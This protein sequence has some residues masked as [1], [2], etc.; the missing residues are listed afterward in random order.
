[1]ATDAGYS[2]SRAS[3]ITK[4]L[5]LSEGFSPLFYFL[6]KHQLANPKTGELSFRGLPASDRYLIGLLSYVTYCADGKILL[7]YLEPELVPD[8]HLK[9]SPPL[10]CA[11]SP[12][13]V[14]IFLLKKP[15]TTGTGAAFSDPMVTELMCLYKCVG[16]PA[17]FMF[18]DLLVN[19]VKR[20]ICMTKGLV[21]RETLI[22][23]KNETE[24]FHDLLSFLDWH[25]GGSYTPGLTSKMI[26]VYRGTALSKLH[27]DV[28]TRYTLF[29]FMG[30][31][32]AY[33]AG[34]SRVQVRES[35]IFDADGI[36]L[37]SMRKFAA[38]DSAP[39]FSAAQKSMEGAASLAFIVS[40]T[41][42]ARVD[43]PMDTS[44][45][46]LFQYDVDNFLGLTDMSLFESLPV[47]GYPF[48]DR[49]KQNYQVKTLDDY[50][51]YAI[52]TQ[53][54]CTTFNSVEDTFNF[55][56]IFPHLAALRGI[57]EEISQGT[58]MGTPLEMLRLKVDLL[59]KLLLE[60]S[61][62]IS[63]EPT[64]TFFQKMAMK[65]RH[66]ESF[67]G[68]FGLPIAPWGIVGVPDGD[69][70]LAARVFDTAIMSQMFR[71]TLGLTRCA[72]GAL[73][74]TYIFHNTAPRWCLRRCM[75][76]NY[77][78]HG[79]GKTYTNQGIQSLLGSVEGVF[80]ELSS[81]TDAALKYVDEINTT[82]I[83][84]MDDVGFSATQLK[85]LRMESSS[86]AAQFKGILDKG[87]LRNTMAE[88]SEGSKKHVT[89]VRTAVHN[90]GFI[91]NTNTVSTF[92]AAWKDRCLILG[93]EPPSAVK[94]AH[95]GEARMQ[96]KIAEAGLGSVTETLFLR[97]NLLQTVIYTLCSDGDIDGR[98][99]MFMSTILD[100]LQ[101]TY[102]SF[103]GGNGSSVSRGDFK[104]QDMAIGEALRLAITAVLDLWLPP[105]MIIPATR[106]GETSGS[107]AQRL[108][109]FRT[110][111]IEFM[112]LPEIT[113]E[114][115]AQ[116]QLF[117]PGCLVQ[118]T[119]MTF[120]QETDGV[121]QRVAQFIDRVLNNTRTVFSIKEGKDALVQLDNP[122]FYDP[123]FEEDVGIF[124]T[125]MGISVKRGTSGVSVVVSMEDGKDSRV[126]SVTMDQNL[127]LELHNNSYPESISGL[128]DT[129]VCGFLEEFSEFPAVRTFTLTDPLQTNVMTL[130]A[131]SG[132][133]KGI[134][135][136]APGVF[137]IH[138]DFLNIG[139]ECLRR[140]LAQSAPLDGW[141][142][143]ED[144]YAFIAP[145]FDN[146]LGSPP[147]VEG[148]LVGE[149]FTDLVYG[150]PRLKRFN[151]EFIDEPFFTANFTH[152][153][154][155]M[156]ALGD[157]C[158]VA[159]PKDLKNRRVPDSQ[160]EYELANEKYTKFLPRERTV[161]E[162][163][164]ELSRYL[165][166]TVNKDTPL[167]E[168]EYFSS[169]EKIPGLRTAQD[170][171]NLYLER[172]GVE[173]GCYLKRR[174]ARLRM[175]ANERGTEDVS[176][177]CS[178][179]ASTERDVCE[180]SP[181][182]DTEMG[183]M[184]VGCLNLMTTINN[185]IQYQ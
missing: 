177:R 2:L 52:R 7:L 69:M 93:P 25:N 106:P 91:W 4:I 174:G 83:V 97:Q 120:N 142:R 167:S 49:T 110:K 73:C 79:Q 156:Y 63:V 101:K 42:T 108:S 67:H 26:D 164:K 94:F 103:K 33:F 82:K 36:I 62:K 116:L 170:S 152:S 128:L 161:S 176:G 127:L 27:Q 131:L 147:K 19:S 146:H 166:L 92:S 11:L 179:R 8:Q 31:V 46:L 80:G 86:I 28:K 130:F 181:S 140:I 58:P 171:L 61:D 60:T 154:A 162:A 180:E 114:V 75:V 183:E 81:L 84:V 178:K 40:L 18:K 143:V 172:Y 115:L 9:L 35:P 47:F 144:A 134:H 136:D 123:L 139:T 72:Q 163:K 173:K 51:L 74:L 29:T 24:Y 38:P 55:K 165:V 125:A 158:Q 66:S 57:V 149:S 145:C 78:T 122:T 119:T 88:Q 98:H 155:V 10:R 1:M 182:E 32:A 184:S 41:D 17:A 76:I 5:D 95:D 21:A 3:F 20:L 107:Y 137:T 12:D 113:V 50:A 43:G 54:P 129:L 153:P 99:K 6:E 169:F 148:R 151:K 105:W 87:Y 23:R 48:V 14:L 68:A 141:Y 16:D 37:R 71:T 121:I 124:K 117:L 102:P 126:K 185:I 118:M 175:A 138:R 135:E 89:V 133:V 157:V 100:A 59:N 168:D 22:V 90:T 56:L 15:T 132:T 96:A 34:K 65:I 160:W 111:A 77:T 44:N 53:S 64:R 45:L 85:N 159:K 39:I 104:I 150:L 70:T 13:I 109:F 112:E 30:T